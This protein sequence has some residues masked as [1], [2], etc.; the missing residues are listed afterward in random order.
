MNINSNTLHRFS[1]KFNESDKNKLAKNAVTSSK[2]KNIILDR[3]KAQKQNRI[4]SNIIDIKTDPSNQKSSGRCWLFALCNMLR[5]KIIKQH[6]LPKE[7]ELSASYLSFYDKLEKCNFFLSI[8]AKYRKEP[9]NSRTNYIFLKEPISDGGNWN[10]VLNLVNKYGLVPKSCFDETEHSQNTGNMDEFLCY[11]L[12]D[13]A[14]LIRNLTDSEY[15]NINTYLEKFMNEIYRILVIFMGEPPKEFNWE[16]LS[17]EKYSIKKNITPLDFYKKY[18]PVNLNDYIL[19]THNPGVKYGRHFTVNDFN[20]MKGGRDIAYINV[21]MDIIKHSIKKSIDKNEALWFGCDVGKYLHNGLGV[22]DTNLVNYR[23]VFDTDI[24]L[25]K[26]N[27][28]QYQTSDVTHA[29]II[30][31]YDNNTIQRSSCLEKKLKQLLSQK[32]TKKVNRSNQNKGRKVKNNKKSRKE[33]SKKCKDKSKTVS[34]NPVTKYLVENSWGKGNIGDEN[35]VM[36]NDYMEEYLY[37]VAVNKKFVDK[38]I[39]SIEKQKPIRF[40][41][42][43]PFGYLLF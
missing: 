21:K 1:N 35:L 33:T 13:Y 22:L 39:I 4:F 6:K 31:G 9:T 34:R 36:T 42:W 7:F 2:L 37:I 8:I 24:S 14:Y 10:M 43:D 40:N 29:M 30:R 25:N 23:S 18:V 17:N 15:K 32:K 28:L 12:K 5:L 38:S 26:Q 20:N 41:L 11:K 27:R 19:L 16:Y 3:N